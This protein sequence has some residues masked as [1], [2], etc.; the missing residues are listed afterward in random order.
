MKL[1]TVD[2]RVA[3]VNG[4]E[5]TS[6][7]VKIRYFGGCKDKITKK[8]IF[9]CKQKSIIRKKIKINTVKKWFNT[10]LSCSIC[11][12]IK[13]LYIHFYFAMA[14]S[15]DQESDKHELIV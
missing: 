7:T 3:K 9:Y 13:G 11:P 10:S 6:D 5:T 8:L 4:N 1:S 2:S 12:A 14:R 15:F